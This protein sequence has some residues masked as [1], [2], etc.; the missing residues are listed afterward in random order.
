MF[1]LQDEMRWT[2]PVTVKVP[3]EGGRFEE[4]QFTAAF[5]LVPESMWDTLGATEDGVKQQLRAAVLGVE[6]VAVQR[7]D[8]AP[9]M[10]TPDELL[11][12]L[13]DVP[14]IRTALLRAYVESLTGTPPAASVGN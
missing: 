4:K 12:A 14:F 7:G 13:L 5:R 11:E 2:W 6:G 1:I 8:S 3:A 10:L 9:D